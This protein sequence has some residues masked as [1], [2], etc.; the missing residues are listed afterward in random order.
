M[1]LFDGSVAIQG[2][3][4]TVCYYNRAEIKRNTV[5]SLDLEFF[6]QIK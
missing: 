5:L 2:I 6:G 1:S 4:F 3:H